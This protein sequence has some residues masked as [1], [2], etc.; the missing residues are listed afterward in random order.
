M[1]KKTEDSDLFTRLAKGLTEGIQFLRGEISLRTFEFEDP[2]PQMKPADIVRLR[3]ERS[4]SQEDLARFLDV[5][6]KTVQSWEQ[7][8]RKPSRSSLMALQI[9]AAK[10]KMMRR[11]A[12]LGNGRK[13]KPA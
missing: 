4:L 3:R 10:P 11:V 5:S 8:S 7:G 9:L 2:P 6:T 1:K 12:G 13:K